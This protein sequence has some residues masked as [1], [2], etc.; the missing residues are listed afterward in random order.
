MCADYHTILTTQCDQQPQNF[1][2]HAF[3]P[4][5]QRLTINITGILLLAW[6]PLC[7][8]CLNHEVVMFQH[9]TVTPPYIGSIVNCYIATPLFLTRSALLRPLPDLPLGGGVPAPAPGHSPVYP[10]CS[11]TGSF[12]HLGVTCLHPSILRPIATCPIF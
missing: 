4:V 9:W 7:G 5:S 3:G 2:R 6:P 10:S 1:E 11:H 8:V 12:A